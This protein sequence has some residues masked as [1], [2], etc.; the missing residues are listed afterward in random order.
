MVTRRRA[1]SSGFSFHYIRPQIILCH[2]I[3]LLQTGSIC[4]VPFS[5]EMVP[6]CQ[7]FTQARFSSV[8]VCCVVAPLSWLLTL[9]RWPTKNESAQEV[10]SYNGGCCAHVKNVRN[11]FC[12]F[13]F[14]LKSTQLHLIVV[15]DIAWTIICGTSLFSSSHL[16][17]NLWP[18][19]TFVR[20]LKNIIKSMNSHNKSLQKLI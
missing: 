9:F 16:I 12:V 20:H 18:L 11:C 7:P 13:L 8:V 19:I 4:C 5:S 6:C 14:S 17:G 1:H 15:S 10:A 2:A 3:C